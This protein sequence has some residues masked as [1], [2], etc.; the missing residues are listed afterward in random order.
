VSILLEPFSASRQVLEELSLN[1]NEIGEQGAAAIVRAKLPNLK[2][3]H[4]EDNDEMPKRY[5]K[6]KYGD[7]ADFGEEEEDEEESEDNHLA[8]LVQ[9]FA[10]TKL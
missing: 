10:S 6:D 8:A 7:I 2:K 3:L 5:I 9:Q 4:L 1:Q